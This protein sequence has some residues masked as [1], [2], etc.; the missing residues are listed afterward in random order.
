MTKVLTG[1]ATTVKPNGTLLV[2]GYTPKQVEF[3]TGGPPN[4]EHM[5]TEAILREVYQ[6]LDIRL[7]EAYEDMLYEGSGHSGN[8]ALIDFVGIKTA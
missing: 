4:P 5:Y 8:S 6:H 1:L 3:G 7:C 2:H